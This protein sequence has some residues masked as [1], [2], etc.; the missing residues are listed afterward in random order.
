[1]SVLERYRAAVAGGEL[2]ADAAQQRA[3]LRLQALGQALA[4]WRPGRRLFFANT[5]PKGLYLWGDVGRG[6]SMLMDL[7]FDA[8][9]VARKLRIHFNEFMVQ[10]HA[11]IHE[12]RQR[13][14]S[15]DPIP[16]VGREI[17]DRAVLLCFDEFQVSDVA[18]A[19]ILGRLFEQLF[20]RGVVIVATSNTP[21]DRLYEG[22]LN[23]QLFLPFIAEIAARLG[24]VELNGAVDYRLQR[25]SGLAVYMHPLGPEADAAMDAAWRRLT[26]RA[27]G[28]AMRLA[29]LGRSV[30]VPQAAKGVARFTFDALCAQPLAGADYLA[31][32]HAFHTVLID[33]IPRLGP[34][35]RNEARRFVVLIDTLYD[36]GVKLVCSAEAAPEELYAA[37]DGADAFRR[38]VSRLHEMQSVDYLKRGH[39]THSPVSS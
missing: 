39:G 18:D 14:G 23:R 5:P 4:A 32:A 19:M 26:D 12:E 33:R 25:L 36:E 21:P 37:G 22:G 6:K 7:F 27:D 28:T 11:R 20:A 9:P 35:Q 8:A 30:P 1:M 10:T 17:A 38:T 16:A 31:I 13:A 2:K 24:V 29:V 3:A 34:D 15:G